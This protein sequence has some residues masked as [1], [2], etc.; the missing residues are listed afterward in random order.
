MIRVPIAVEKPH[1]TA[2][3]C[4]DASEGLAALVGG[5]VGL[6][7]WALLETHL[8]RCA[9]CR[10]ADASLRQRAAPRRPV[11]QLGVPDIL[12]KAL[13]GAQVRVTWSTA[14]RPVMRALG[15]AVGH[16]AEL[17]ATV[18]VSL[19]SAHEPVGRAIAR[20]RQD[21][22]LGIMRFV[23]DVAH[24]RRRLAFRLESSVAGVANALGAV[25][26]GIARSVKRAIRF[27]ASVRAV[28]VVLALTFA[29]LA[30]PQTN[31]PQPLARPPALPPPGP[32]PTRLGPAQV[33][34]ARAEPTR[35]EPAPAEP[36]H[37]ATSPPVPSV[38]EK[39]GS[40]VPLRTDARRIAP[41]AAPPR[42][43]TAVG[44]SLPGVSASGSVR[45]LV[46]APSTRL[47]E[48]SVSA[49]HVIGRL[50]PR[51]PSA[52]EREFIALLA[53]VGGVELR[54]GERAWFTAIEVVVPQSRYN[55][56]VDGL[57]RIGS[58]RLEA[59]R[60]RLPDAVH[61][62]IRVSD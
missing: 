48:S 57:A 24:W 1:A 35:L 21:L 33:E 50:S 17:L 38:E 51:N 11:T 29:L 5:H 59:A 22:A 23:P 19:G 34:P 32:P 40:G 27:G 62:T 25:C 43:A 30:L 46:S 45:E 20:A 53:D 14:L 54:R 36:T 42:V 18:R 10:Q 12:R 6:T 58:W 3:T 9:G 41:R 39:I 44:R 60:S 55:D 52:A 56:F 47:S 16:R 2:M 49:P 31:G 15:R 8:A 37:L 26:R 28:G 61:M 13:E 7:E 4:E